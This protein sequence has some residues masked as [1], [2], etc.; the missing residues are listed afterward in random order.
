M[1]KSAL[2]CHHYA[3]LTVLCWSSAFVLTKVG[4]RHFSVP[5]LGLVRCAVACLAFACLAFTGR[6]AP[7]RAADLPLFL[8]S[9]LTGFSVYLL[10]FNQ[11]AESLDPAT[12]CI[13]ISTAP[14]ITALLAGLIFKERLNALGWTAI[15][16][17]F[18]GILI[19][20]L[21][22]G[23]FSP[24]AGIIWT[25]AA[26][27][28]ISCYSLLQRKLTRDYGALRVTAYSFFLGTPVLFYFAPQTAAELQS[29]SFA[30]L[31]NACYLG[32][33]PSAAAYLLWSKAF[34]VAPKT[35]TVTNYMFLTPFLALL[36][37][38]LVIAQLPGPETFAGGAVI[39][40]SLFLFAKAGK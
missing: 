29:A 25:E 24:D 20:T 23:S 5:A 9:G 6:L 4:L 17:A 39:L 14:I 40:G 8:L 19:L 18:C 2:G 37:E 22:N 15:G 16:L 32:L 12:S 35:S 30:Q 38:Y 26:A 28:S 1:G 13:L 27:L 21:W 3:L 31:A 10:L 36:M 34:S 7:P 33:F 11:G